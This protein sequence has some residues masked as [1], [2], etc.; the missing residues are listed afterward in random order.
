MG[1]ELLFLCVCEFFFNGSRSSVKMLACY[2]F[3]YLVL[4]VSKIIYQ[5][6]KFNDFASFCIPNLTGSLTLLFCLSWFVYLSSSVSFYSNDAFLEDVQRTYLHIVFLS[7][8]L[9][10]MRGLSAIKA[11]YSLVPL[12][13]ALTD[14]QI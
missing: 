14:V 11:I 10:G 9:T 4:L 3:T 7:F 13:D 5:K 2:L 8:F 1:F 6:Q 12:R